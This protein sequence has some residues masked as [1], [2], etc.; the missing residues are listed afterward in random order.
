MFYGRKILDAVESVRRTHY[1]SQIL[2]EDSLKRMEEHMAKTYAVIDEIVR[3]AEDLVATNADLVRSNRAANARAE[4]A[5][6]ELSLF[7]SNDDLEDARQLA[8]QDEDLANYGAGRAAQLRASIDAAKADPSVPVTPDDGVV[9]GAEVKTEEPVVEVPEPEVPVVDEE[10][11]V[12]PEVP[13]V[14]EEPSGPGEVV[15]GGDDAGVV[16]VEPGDIV[17]VED[18]KEDDD[19]SV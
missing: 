10:P 3:L 7:K 16:I 4:A 18:S 1:R 2:I 6:A 8:A 14:D 15:D 5:N 12:E 13:V 17:V 9:P 19:T 11:A